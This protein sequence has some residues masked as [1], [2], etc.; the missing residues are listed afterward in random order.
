[1][2]RRRQ[3]QTVVKGCTS[4]FVLSILV[5]AAILFTAGMFVAVTVIVR[6]EP[7]FEGR[8]Y[9]RPKMKLKRLQ[10]PVKIEQKA[11]SRSPDFSHRI[12]A[13]PVYTKKVEFEMPSFSG[14]GGTDFTLSTS[15]IS[16]GDL[17]FAIAQFNVFGIRSRGEKVLF[18]LDTSR[19]MM[20]DEIGG[21]PAYQLIKDELTGLLRHVPPTTLF[22][23]IIFEANGAAESFTPEMSTA[24]EENVE[25]LKHWLDPLNSYKDR[26]G[27]S[28]LG[29]RGTPVVFEPMPP[30]YNLQRGWMAALSYGLQRGADSIYWLGI[31]DYMEWIDK[32]VLADCRKGKP[33]ADP[34]G[35]L[36]RT[37][38][39][40]Y[41]PY[42]G[43]ERW[44]KLVAEAQKKYDEE[45]RVRLARGM[46]IRV[47]PD[48][49]GYSSLVR[50]YFPGVLYLD[51]RNN[52]HRYSYTDK[53]I[54]DYIRAMQKKYN[55]VHRDSGFIGLKRQKLSL[56]VIH[57][58][59]NTPGVEWQPELVRL[60]NIPPQMNG[61]YARLPGLDAIKTVSTSSRY[62]R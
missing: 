48:G 12:T 20:V 21:I 54:A 25:K 30:V 1:M 7:K 23:V 34:S 62:R 13:P 15:K 50:T 36:P 46:P 37:R 53:D 19:N 35:H 27:I 9:V 24:N 40:N 42:G 6:E 41:D 5:H 26:Y 10:V 52:Q 8:E 29:Y 59:G 39:I 43:K 14:T 11:A 45:N 31:N 33:M 49:L 47:L 22:N 17:S 18:I 32:D 51:Y 28:T 57:F 61:D 58:T 4:A 2:F 3:K 56:N 38:E 55:L 16:A 44:D 60:R